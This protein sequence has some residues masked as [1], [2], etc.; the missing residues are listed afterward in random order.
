V[1]L[2][3]QPHG[4]AHLARQRP[5]SRTEL[6]KTASRRANCRIQNVSRETFSE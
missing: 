6:L 4:R 2:S 1:K 3:S 5:D